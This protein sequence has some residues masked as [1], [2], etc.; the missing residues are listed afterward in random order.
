MSVL[1]A[2]DLCYQLDLGTDTLKDVV[3]DALAHD[4]VLTVTANRPAADLARHVDDIKPTVVKILDQATGTA[5][6]LF[7]EWVISQV[8][9]YKGFQPASLGEA[10]AILSTESRDPNRTHLHEWLN[11]TRPNEV[12]CPGGPPGNGGP[13]PTFGTVPCRRHR[14]K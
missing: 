13:H 1:T 5:N 11:F 4:R 6:Y 7:P 2:F 9:L 3:D 8:A 14:P 10:V 12:I